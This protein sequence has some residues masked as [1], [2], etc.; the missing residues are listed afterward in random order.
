MLEKPGND[1]ERVSA[2]YRTSANLDARIRLHKEYSTNQYGWLS[3]VFDHLLALPDDAAILEIGCGTGQLWAEN[4]GRIPTGWQITLTD[5][6]A[7]MLTQSQAALASLTRG[8]TFE[9]ADA[10]RLPF[11]AD[12]FDAVIAN[13]MLYHVPDLPKALAEVTR[14]L[15]P[16]G[17]FFA[18]TNGIAHM[19]VLAAMLAAF[20][21]RLRP[22]RSLSIG[23]FTLENGAAQLRPH[24]G[25]VECHRYEDA[26]VVD[27]AAPLVDYVLSATPADQTLVPERH[28]L[29]AF[30]HTELAAQ[31]GSITI[32][33]STGLFIAQ[34]PTA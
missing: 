15:K 27:R 25:R 26:L 4:A 7:G 17:R 30:F 29:D 1:P 6:S 22:D 24:F 28:A 23:T 14:V 20:D 12:Q 16:G 21:E 13:H 34:Q 5:Q 31:G 9:Q 10:E 32:A 11:A 3:W 33:K 2:Q 18:A 19:Q 8:I